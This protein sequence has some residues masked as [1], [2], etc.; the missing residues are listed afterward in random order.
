MLYYY[1][2]REMGDSQYFLARAES[3]EE[4][5]RCF[6]KYRDREYLEFE[7]SPERIIKAGDNLNAVLHI[8]N[9]VIPY[10]EQE[11]YR[12][13]SE[14]VD[15]HVHCDQSALVWEMADREML[16]VPL[17]GINRED[18]RAWCVSYTLLTWL[19]RNGEP[20]IFSDYGT[21]GWWLVYSVPITRF[22]E[23]DVIR[24]IAVERE[25]L[26]GRS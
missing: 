10:S 9:L 11:V 4:F 21:T 2:C 22:K 3:D 24:K 16:T 26:Y 14:L 17:E 8:S 20:V 23:M 13:T 18:Y 6:Q 25:E 1:I 7:V 12:L 15:D 5:E 19:K